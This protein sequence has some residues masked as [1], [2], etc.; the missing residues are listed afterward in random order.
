MRD[1]STVTVDVTLRK[2][3]L[4]AFMLTSF[5]KSLRAFQVSLGNNL[6][7][8]LSILLGITTSE[9]LICEIP[10][11]LSCNGRAEQIRAFRS[12]REPHAGV[13][14]NNLACEGKARL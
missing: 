1:A 12:D 8:L 14:R 3:D 9:V 4:N 11:H 6:V 5:F 2:P 7:F 13:C 10:S